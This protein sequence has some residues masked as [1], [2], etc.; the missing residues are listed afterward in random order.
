[1]AEAI[2]STSRSVQ[3]SLRTLHQNNVT[4]LMQKLKELQMDT[5]TSSDEIRIYAQVESKHS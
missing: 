3:H 1:M 5:D 2:Q 4:M